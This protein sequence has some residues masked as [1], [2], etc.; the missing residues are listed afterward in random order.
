[1][2]ASNIFLN[3]FLVTIVGGT[4]TAYVSLLRD[5]ISKRESALFSLRDLIK[6]VDDLYRATKQTKRMI[7]S[8]LKSVGERYEIEAA[9]F[10]ARMDDLSNTQLKLE[11]VR[12]AVRTRSDLFDEERKKR[13]IK[14]IEYSE[15]YL[16]DVVEEFEK[17]FIQWDGDVCR[18]PASC[19][20]LMDYLG[21]RWMPAQIQEDFE[22]M[23]DAVTCEE[24]YRAFESVVAKVKMTDPNWLRHKT[25]ADECMLLAIR[26]M[27]DVVIDLQKQLTSHAVITMVLLPLSTLASRRNRGASAGDDGSVASNELITDQVGSKPMEPTLSQ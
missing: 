16:N 17:R 5:L 10:A 4:F 13:I 15:K 24:R 26:E 22:K 8:R 3:F 27:R 23:E 9:F 20:M 19:K 11:Q 7:R 21:E 25:V 12:N 6:Q 14:E 1:M 18:I 2:G